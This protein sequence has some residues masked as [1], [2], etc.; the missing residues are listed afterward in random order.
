[1]LRSVNDDS[2][3][4]A[5]SV[6]SAEAKTR[7]L[8]V[9]DEPQLLRLIGRV[10]ARGPYEILDALDGDAAHKAV[11]AAEPA[12]AIL[13]L[14]IPPAGGGKL[15]RELRAAIPGLRIVLTSGAD[16]KSELHSELVNAA[17]SYLRKPFAPRAL[18]E[19]VERTLAG[20]SHPDG[21][22]GVSGGG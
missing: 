19:M 11:A 2:L 18:L 12:L 6:D 14:S 3:S 20:E 15:M 7:I 9:D 16:L 5:S 22:S 4:S 13:D 8:V 17:G 1:M 10:L 21:L